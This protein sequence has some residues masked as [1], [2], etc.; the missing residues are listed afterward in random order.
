MRVI[1][2]AAG[3]GSRLLPLT[4]SCPKGLIPIAGR[5]LLE[6]TFEQL[7]EA[8]IDEV[9][10]VSGYRSDL[11]QRTLNDLRLRPPLHFIYNSRYETANN[12]V[13]LALTRD[14]WDEEF[15]VINSDICFRPQLLQTLLACPNDSMV[16]D[17]SRHHEQIDMKVELRDGLIWHLDKNLPLER[18]DGE[19]FG[20]SHW[21]PTGAHRLSLTIDR[22]LNAGCSD[23]WVEFAI[24]EVA[25]SMAITP[26]YTDSFQWI[27]VDTL[28]D[29]QAAERFFTE[30]KKDETA[31]FGQ[32]PVRYNTPE[33][34]SL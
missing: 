3:I 16:I 13:S 6:R 7:Y 18:T 14:W 26:L 4:Q 31:I 15:C 11:L 34:Q 2:P 29:F 32:A 24:R 33:S 27:E 19:F 5:S 10:C 28:A 8:E 9:I 20:L 25:K 30:E 1:I 22:L 21:T 12:I 23:V 17:N